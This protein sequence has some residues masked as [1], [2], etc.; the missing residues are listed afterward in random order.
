MNEQEILDLAVD[1]GAYMLRS[2]AEIYRVE[3][4]VSYICQAYGMTEV[5]VFAIPSS[6]V[7]TICKD[8][9][10]Y[11]KTRRVSDREINLGKLD[12]L[13]SLSR[14]LC[15]HT[16]GKEEAYFRFHEIKEEKGFSRWVLVLS[17]GLVS[18]CL[19]VFFG[20]S[21]TDAL[22]ALIV[23][24][25]M[26]IT[27]VIMERYE[28]NFLFLNIIGGLVTALGV[29]VLSC[30]GMTQNKDAIIIGILM[31]LVPGIALTNGMRDLIGGDFNA[32]LHRFLE[33]LL[34]AT[35]IALGAVIPIIFAN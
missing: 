9:K 30:F 25:I 17:V 28:A 27:L 31:N 18:A 35:G 8:E 14:Y 15:A 1:V 10:Y 3:Q 16:P 4:S 22:I 7:A 11:T 19:T 2:G 32:A 21:F 20:G 5:D 29:N 12:R 33:A 13:N 34:I 23:G 6:I 24:F 26:K